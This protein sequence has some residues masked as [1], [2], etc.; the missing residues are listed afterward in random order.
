MLATLTVFLLM[1]A[2]PPQQEQRFTPVEG[3][4]LQAKQEAA[5]RQAAAAGQ[6]RFWTAHAFDVRPGVVVD[7]EVVNADGR[8]YISDGTFDGSSW[9]GPGL[10]PAIETRNL[11]VFLL[12]EGARGDI[13]RVEVYNLARRREYAGH[14]VYWAG[15]ASNEESLSFLR[16]L[17]DAARSPELAA[18]AVCAVALHDDRRVPDILTAVA[19]SGA[20]ERV[21]AQAVR[22]LGHH[23]PT[24]AARDFLAALA[25]DAREP[26]EVRRSAITAYGRAR[27]AQA[28]AFLQSLYDQ[29]NDRELKRRVLSSLR[30]N[31][32]RDAAVGLLI[33]VATQDADRELRRRALAQLGEVAGERALGTL[34][35]TASSPD[36]DVELQKQALHAISRRPS[37]EAVPLLIRAAQTHARPE[38]RKHALVL[39]GRSGDPAAV[40]FLRAFLTK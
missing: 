9:D 15:R 21:R 36:A 3:A 23:P 40:E 25:R 32:N 24:P 26:H 22:S 7:F 19:R 8:T 34:R 16:G 5:V 39:L 14:P 27:D 1:L 28:L 33:R 35:E 31:E 10:D 4:G 11:A 37:A 38:I 2:P 13:V 18:A 17:V 29:L 20:D 6:T 30:E 12:R